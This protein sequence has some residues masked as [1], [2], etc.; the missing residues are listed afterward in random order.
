[1]LSVHVQ[2]LKFEEI[3]EFKTSHFGVFQTIHVFS[4]VVQVR[5]AFIV[6]FPICYRVN[7]CSE[8]GWLDQSQGFPFDGL[9]RPFSFETN[10]FAAFISRNA[11]LTCI[12]CRCRRIP[13]SDVNVDLLIDA[14]KSFNASADCNRASSAVRAWSLCCGRESRQSATSVAILLR[15]ILVRTRSAFLVFQNLR[16]YLAATRKLECCARRFP[17]TR[18]QP[19]T[20]KRT[21]AN[22]RV[23]QIGES[24]S[25]VCCSG[26]QYRA[27]CGGASAR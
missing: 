27:R 26:I 16:C 8:I 5:A 7:T 2:S 9:N 25:Q 6:L 11:I 12:T 22:S 18:N 10:S 19:T 24:Q 1:M 4:D 23:A 20:G 14:E 17:T 3:T 15:Q 21:D 13:V